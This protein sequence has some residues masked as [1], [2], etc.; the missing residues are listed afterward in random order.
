MRVIYA[1]ATC[2]EQVYEKLCGDGK[3]SPSF[4][5]QKYNRLFIEGLAALCPV[6]VVCYPPIDTSELETDCLEL[7]EETL[8]NAS[9]HYV[10][11]YRRTARKLIHALCAVFTR[12]YRL[13][14]RDSAVV[15]DCMN[16]VISLGAMLAARLKGAKCVGIVTDLPEFQGGG[17]MMAISRF[18]IRHCTHYVVMTEPMNQRINPKGKPHAVLEGHADITMAS[19]T[20]SLESKGE[21]RICLYAGTIH[22]IYGIQRLVEGFRLADIPDAELHIYGSGDYQQELERIATED[23]RIQYG[24]LLLPSQVVEKEMEATLLI[25]PRPTDEEYVKYSFPSKTMEYLSTG[26]PL[27][28]TALPGM[29]KEYYPHVYLIRD[30]S[31]EG[32]AEALRRTLSNSRQELHEK[33][34]GAREFVLSQRN[35][36]MQAKKVLNLLEGSREA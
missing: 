29:P 34:L 31:A 26:T 27:L 15:M 1:A 14:D 35:N 10:R 8:G 17:P 22:A 7:E 21:K 3:N 23:P 9:Y 4:Q 5:A 6:D 20:P 32:I 12:T 11:T 2:T 30:E 25:N 18:V 24:G 13:A 16:Q 33:G 19:R 28:T 36:V